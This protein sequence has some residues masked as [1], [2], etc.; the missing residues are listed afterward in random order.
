MQVADSRNLSDALRDA[1]A[2]GLPAVVDVLIDRGPSPD[3]WRADARRSG[4]DLDLHRCTGWMGFLILILDA[5]GEWLFAPVF[6]G[7]TDGFLDG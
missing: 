7:D 1:R 6:K 4:G 2:S 3:D 5:R